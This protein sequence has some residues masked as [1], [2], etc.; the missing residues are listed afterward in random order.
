MRGNMMA[1]LKEKEFEGKRQDGDKQCL[2]HHLEDS[3]IT[4]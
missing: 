3:L 4:V 1:K 2:F